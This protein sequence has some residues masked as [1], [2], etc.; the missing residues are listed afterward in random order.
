MIIYFENNRQAGVQVTYDLNGERHYDY[1]ENMYRFRVWVS[2]EFD[3]E[4]VEITDSNYRQLVAEG[5]I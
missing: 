1:F 4:T 2:H 3:C 5:V